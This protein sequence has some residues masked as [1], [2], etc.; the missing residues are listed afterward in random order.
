MS[1]AQILKSGR[2][3]FVTNTFILKSQPCVGAAARCREKGGGQVLSPKYRRNSGVDERTRQLWP[4]FS[5][6]AP[7]APGESESTEKAGRKRAA[8]EGVSVGLMER[9]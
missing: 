7:E 5:Q 9:P 8:E 2:V 3:N 6:V 4:R 1:G